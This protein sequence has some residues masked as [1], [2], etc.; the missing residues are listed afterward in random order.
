MERDRGQP[1][2]QS[3]EDVRALSHDLLHRLAAGACG[4]GREVKQEVILLPQ[5]FVAAENLSLYLY[6]CSYRLARLA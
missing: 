1:L 4:L 6:A 3:S 2:Y 5:M